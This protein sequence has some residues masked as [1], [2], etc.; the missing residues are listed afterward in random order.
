MGNNNGNN[1]M[2]IKNVGTHDIE[3]SWLTSA[4][5]TTVEAGTTVERSTAA[6]LL[7]SGEL[8]CKNGSCEA[9]NIVED[10]M[11]ALYTYNAKCN[12]DRIRVWRN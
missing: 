5:W 11:S 3:I 4:G 12:G 10:S 2:K 1:N 8:R 6:N 9:T 7:Y